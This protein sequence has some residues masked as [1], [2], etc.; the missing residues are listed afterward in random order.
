[1]DNKSA[2]RLRDHI[3]DISEKLSDEP[4]TMSGGFA[5]SI[6]Q[7]KQ[8]SLKR[9]MCGQPRKQ[10]RIANLTVEA[11]VPGLEHNIRLDGIG[12]GW[13]EADVDEEPDH[14]VMGTSVSSTRHAA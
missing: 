2:D 5:C 7:I 3:V 12:T 11:D 14:F 13:R 10:G 8:T 6:H 1:M 9:M 4:A